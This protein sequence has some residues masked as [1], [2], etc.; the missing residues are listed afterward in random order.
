MF[1]IPAISIVS[2][3]HCINTELIRINAYIE[4]IENIH[5]F[6]NNI[7]NNEITRRLIRIYIFFFRKIIT[8]SKIVTR[9]LTYCKNKILTKEYLR[10]KKKKTLKPL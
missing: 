3:V 9:K 7:R 10:Q 4:N 2:K 1:I 8:S 5:R 6:T